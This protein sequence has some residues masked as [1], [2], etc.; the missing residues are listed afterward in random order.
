ML[1]LPEYDF[2]GPVNVTD[3]EKTVQGYNFWA[4]EWKPK[5]KPPQRCRYEADDVNLI[6]HTDLHYFQRR[7]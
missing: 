5:L 1:L 3:V 4:G 6:W 2:L 7:D